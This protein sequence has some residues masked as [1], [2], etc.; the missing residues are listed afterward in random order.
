[1]KT[2][3]QLIAC[4]LFFNSC[5][6]KELKPKD[7]ILWVEDESNGLHK[8]E[9]IGDLIYDVQYK[10]TDY[11]LCKTGEVD[12]VVSDGLLDSLRAQYDSLIYFTITLKNSTG[13]DPIS[14]GGNSK[15]IEESALYYFQYNFQQDIYL[16]T[17]EN[18]I[19][20]APVLFHFE[21][22]YTINN[23]KV[24]LLAF[25]KKGEMK[26]DLKLVINSKYLTSGLVKFYFEKEL[27]AKQ[28]RMKL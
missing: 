14:Q 7:Y 27:F 3:I 19:K 4:L 11:I 12:G 10:P 24:F 17:A 5:S 16:E 28:A 8:V 9:Q 21:R 2:I 20:F 18:K 6:N 1:L 23:A 25:D 13:E 22:M 26:E 15:E